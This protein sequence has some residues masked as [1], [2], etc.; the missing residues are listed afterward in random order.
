LLVSLFGLLPWLRQR[1]GPGSWA[2]CAL[3]AAASVLTHLIPVVGLLYVM[4]PLVVYVGVCERGV[5][6]GTGPLVVRNTLGIGLIGALLLAVCL[7]H[8]FSTEVSAAEVEWVR[9]FQQQWSGGAWGGA[10]DNAPVTIPHYLVEKV[11]GDPF[12]ALSCLGMLVLAYRRPHLA[13][14]SLIWIL[15]AVGL[16]IN[17]MHWVLPLSYALYPERVALL[18]LLPLALGIS[19]LLDS[20]RNL[21]P[22]TTL[23]IWVMA[24]LVLFTSAR[25]NEKLFH[26]GLAAHCLLTGADLQAMQWLRVNT[27]PGDVVQNRYGDAGLWIP[28]LAFSGITDPHLSPFYFDEFR[29]GSTRLRAKYVYVGKKKVLGE[30]IL[31]EEFESAPAKYRR[32]Y[33]HGG[34]IIYEVIG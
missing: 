2:L 3:I 33:D 4:I 26:H 28:A 16:I 34:V 20:V 1:L 14:A 32:V 12:L 24:A 7:P 22:K 19:A 21:F 18:L 31:L 8:L 25:E 13:I 6:Q 5:W 30:P 11:F 10:L 23:P 29:A 17:S 27:N 15:T 9:R